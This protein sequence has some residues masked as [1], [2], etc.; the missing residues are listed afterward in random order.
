MHRGDARP[1]RS[2]TWGL[3]WQLYL[4]PM[5]EH[6]ERIFN[7]IRDNSLLDKKNK[8]PQA[9]AIQRSLLDLIGNLVRYQQKLEEF[10]IAYA[11]GD[12]HTR[13]IMVRQLK[14]RRD[15]EFRE[16]DHELD[17]KLIDLE[18]VRRDGDAALD[19]GEL[20]VDLEIM[21]NSL[22]GSSDKRP[23]QALIDS[24]NANYNEFA[25]ERRDPNFNTRVQLARARAII[26]VAKGRTKAGEN[27]LR[28]SRRGQAISIAHEILR[29]AE[30]AVIYL[31]S[32]L[33][34]F[35]D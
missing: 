34:A 9:N 31:E 20:L 29:Y 33:E 23:I 3:L 19:A 4:L 8:Q 1:P 27:A 28:E 26:R 2:A 22:R 12:L 15:D 5:Q 21:L 32:V 25:Q 6:V 14:R 10:P 13:N 35:G 30:Q 18:K 11:H 24:L 7:Y 17:F 16:Q